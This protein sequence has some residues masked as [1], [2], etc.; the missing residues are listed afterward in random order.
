METGKEL[1][2]NMEEASEILGVMRAIWKLSEEAWESFE[3]EWLVVS[4][5]TNI[6]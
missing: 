5:A 2:V 1:W 3:K 6:W 4:I